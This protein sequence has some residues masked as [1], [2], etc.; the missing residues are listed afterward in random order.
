M[1][2]SYYVKAIWDPEAAVWT[3]QTDIPSLVIEADDLAEFEALME[4][5][6][7]EMLAAN[8]GIHNQTIPIEFSAASRRE[9]L[10]A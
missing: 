8:A 10:V 1:Q 7:P 3:S 4:A 9:L 2:R 6:G 5:L